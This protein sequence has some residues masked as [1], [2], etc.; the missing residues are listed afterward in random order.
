MLTH[1]KQ[2]TNTM[3]IGAYSLQ[4]GEERK[5]EIIRVE[6]QKVKGS[7][8]KE[9]DCIVAILKDEKPFILNKTNCKTLT[10]LFGTPYLQNWVGGHIIIFAEIVSA[11]GDKVD[12][13]RIR[14]TKPA[15]PSLT[16]QSPKWTGAYD[17]LKNSTTTLIDI[18]KHYSLTK[19]NKTLLLKALIQ[20]I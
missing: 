20:T 15:L 9:T 8:G 13:L 1:W 16:P 3:Y 19:E 6:R 4:P 10:K 18:E 2:F 11:F 12:A 7:D 14:P 5:V 17:A